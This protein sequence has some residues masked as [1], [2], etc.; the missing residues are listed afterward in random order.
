MISQTHIHVR[1]RFTEPILGTVPEDST[2]WQT[3]LRPRQAAEEAKVTRRANHQSGDP[4]GAEITEAL[5]QHADEVTAHPSFRDRVEASRRAKA[6]ARRNDEVDPEDDPAPLPVTSFFR[7]AD[8]T[9][10]LFNYQVFGHLKESANIL[11]TA[12]GVIALRS[13]IENYCVITPRRIRF[14]Q[15]IYGEISRPL[16]A[17]TAM[18]PRVAIATSDVVNAG[19]ELAFDVHILPNPKSEVTPAVI[20]EILDWGQ[21]RGMGQWRT[22]GWGLYELVE[23]TVTDDAGEVIPEAKARKRVKR[24]D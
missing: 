21:Y 3:F 15:P 6:D 1:I 9:P 10:M 11:K 16:R 19:A 12:L 20:R 8:G 4:T 17:Q 5:A 24:A 14:S 18:G 13:K 23:F 7:D 22:G 2:T